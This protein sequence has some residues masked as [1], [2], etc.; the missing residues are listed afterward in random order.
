MK[1]LQE[2]GHKRLLLEAGED[3]K[4]CPI[5]YILECIKTIYS[6]KH[7][8][9]EIRRVNIDIAATTV[10]NYRKLKE[11]GIGTYLLFQETYHKP[12]YISMHKGPK[13]NYEWHTEAMDRAMQAGIDDVHWSFVWIV[14]L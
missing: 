1:A 11:A 7:N 8:G 10:E 6:V 2:L 4:N 13:Q 9:G 14:R 3:D 12:T 5:E